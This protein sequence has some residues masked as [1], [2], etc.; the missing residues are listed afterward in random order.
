[1]D[2]CSAHKDSR[3]QVTRYRSDR[4][5]SVRWKSCLLAPYL[6]LIDIFIPSDDNSL[7][8]PCLGKPSLHSLQR[9]AEAGERKVK[10]LLCLL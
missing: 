8:D 6:V 2:A 10:S 7:L 9:E 1:M 4:Y 3:P 5:Q